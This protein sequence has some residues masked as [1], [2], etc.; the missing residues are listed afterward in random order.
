MSQ[1]LDLKA[2][3]HKA[4]RSF[5]QDGL[6]DLYLGGLML[7]LS[8]FFSVPESGSGELAYLGLALLGLVIVAL[9]F[10]LGR[11]YITAPRMGQVRF[12]PERQKRKATLFWVMGLFF[13]VTL[14]LFLYSLYV[15]NESA[16]GRPLDLNLDPAL[17]RAIVAS[18]A[19]LIVGVSVIVK[20]YFIEFMRGYYI[21]LLMGC[22][23]FLTLWL[24][25]SLPMIVAGLL[26][27]SPGLV[28]FA[29]FLR[30][31]PLPPVEAQHGN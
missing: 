6:L 8:L 26:T 31:H 7:V 18:I 24:D 4:F 27:L 9:I 20:S 29:N 1:N 25:S 2:I 15:W 23:F 16:S 3:E 28:L 19:A 14:G 10:Q 30:R 12:G 21:A 13:L 22:G 11:K 17:E 5:H